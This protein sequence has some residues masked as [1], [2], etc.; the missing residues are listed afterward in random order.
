M[1]TLREYIDQLD[2]ISRRDVL[3]G[4]GAA[5]AGAA[6][7]GAKAYD[8][9][10]RRGD[11]FALQLSNEENSAL[12]KAVLLYWLQKN[13]YLPANPELEQKLR[14]LVEINNAFKNRINQAYDHSKDAFLGMQRE[15]PNMFRER[16]EVFK[17]EERAIIQNLS[18][19]SR[20]FESK[21][22][23]IKETS[24]EAISKIDQLSR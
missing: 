23:Q 13:R 16:L 3:K 2:E 6:S 17:K 19:I 4:A 1:K 9:D 5:A 15:D 10:Y 14:N 7:S 18:V 20:A 12:G 24:P 8:I 22:S 21:E 11:A